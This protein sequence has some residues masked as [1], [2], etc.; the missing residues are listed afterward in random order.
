M[1]LRY[2]PRVFSCEPSHDI[3]RTEMS[4]KPNRARNLDSACLTLFYSVYIYSA[5]EYSASRLI[6]SLKIF[7]DIRDQ[8]FS[9]YPVPSVCHG[10]RTLAGFAP[11]LVHMKIRGC[12]TPSTIG[13]N[14]F[15]ARLELRHYLV[16]SSK[17]GQRHIAAIK[18]IL[19]GIAPIE[20]GFK[21][22][23]NPPFRIGN[24]R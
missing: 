19:T 18:P 7:D 2:D 5:Y 24:V 16:P 11:K 8:S 17:T 15:P 21:S 14:R 4:A 10:K 12:R 20:I 22:D 1:R 23:Q 13:K 9:P 6:E 3:V